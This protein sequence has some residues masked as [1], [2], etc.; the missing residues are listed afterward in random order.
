MLDL[1]VIG[2]GLGGLSAALA[3]SDAGLSVRVIAKGLGSIHWGAGAIDVLGYLPGEQQPVRQPLAALAALP[4]QH[5]YQVVGQSQVTQALQRLQTALAAMG[6]T[7]ASAANAENLLLPSPVGAGRPTFLA[8]EAQLAGSIHKREPMVIVGFTGMRDFFPRLIAENLTRQGI[9]ARDEFLPLT[10]LTERRD[11]N[12]VQ[13]AT[14]LDDGKSRQRLAN[15]LKK[16]VRSGERVGLPAI[17]GLHQHTQVMAE[18][19]DAV[20]A[21][22]FEIP[23]LPPSVPGVRLFHALRQLLLQRNVR[24]EANMEVVGFQATGRKV[25]WVETATSSRP[26]RHRAGQYLLATGGVLGGGFNSDASGR[27]WEVVFQLPLTVPQDRRQ[28]FRPHFFDPQGQ[29]VFQGGVAIDAHFRPLDAEN[30][31]VYDNVR[32]AG[33]LLAH[34]DPIG[35]RSVEGVAVATGYAAAQSLLAPA[36]A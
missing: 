10:L 19:A 25:E 9:A 32:A 11:S 8:P 34:A 1:L 36:A 14:A 6:L 35:E 28:W 12:T 15:E 16:R 5:P 20:G 30:R 29:P 22:V 13:L 18:L 33:G 2:A 26:L 7:Y 3:A 23:T 21:P 24:V 31:V 27:F 17:L 4:P